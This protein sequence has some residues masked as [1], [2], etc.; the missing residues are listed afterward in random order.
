MNGTCQAILRKTKRA[1]TNTDV[2]DRLCG[3]QRVTASR[4]ARASLRFKLT[5][6]NTNQSIE[7]KVSANEMAKPCDAGCGV[8]VISGF[9][10]SKRQRQAAALLSLLKPTPPS[11]AKQNQ[12]TFDSIK[13]LRALCRQSAPRAP[14][15]RS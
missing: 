12:S 9:N 13:T 2:H 4:L 3:A 5:E 7:L 6:Q 1:A 8:S 14:P 10:A 15:S 11:L